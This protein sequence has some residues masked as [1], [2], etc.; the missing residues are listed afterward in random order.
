MTIRSKLFPAATVLV[1]IAAMHL[2][3]GRGVVHASGPEDDLASEAALIERNAAAAR[4]SRVESGDVVLKRAAPGLTEREIDLPAV[5]ANCAAQDDQHYQDCVTV[6]QVLDALAGSCVDCRPLDYL[7]S[8]ETGRVVAIVLEEVGL[9]GSIPPEIGNLAALED[10]RL[11]GNDLTGS[12][13]TELGSLANLQ[14]LHLALN[15]LAGSIPP[16]LGSLTALKELALS[17]NEL[18]GS[19]PPEIGH[20]AALEVLAL[21][22]NQLTGSLPTELGSLANLRT[23]ILS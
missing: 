12:I 7:T 2:P 23:L 11:V 18:T 15:R 17:F 21:G 3:L 5:Q 19:I 10:L 6:H 20:L 4:A 22:G 14:V 9:A 13:P 1:L 16:E 8:T